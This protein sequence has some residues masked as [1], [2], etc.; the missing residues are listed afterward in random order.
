MAN[1]MGKAYGLNKV[2]VSS[3]TKSQSFANLGN[4][5]GVGEPSPEEI[6]L[7]YRKHLGLSLQAPEGGRV[8]YS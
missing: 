2:R 4:L 7:T 3:Q 1:V 6:S 5:Q 8:D